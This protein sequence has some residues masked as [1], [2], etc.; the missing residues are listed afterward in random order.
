MVGLFVIYRIQTPPTHKKRKRLRQSSILGHIDTRHQLP[1]TNEMFNGVGST[2]LRRPN[3][4][5]VIL[6]EDRALHTI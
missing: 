5:A 1:K 6:G 3:P 2:L 4:L